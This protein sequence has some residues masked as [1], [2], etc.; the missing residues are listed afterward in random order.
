MTVHSFARIKLQRQNM[1]ND[2]R[3]I[4][5][6]ISSGQQYAHRQETINT[7]VPSPHRVMFH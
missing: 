3:F 1:M 6:C 5:P 2:V 4:F 7:T